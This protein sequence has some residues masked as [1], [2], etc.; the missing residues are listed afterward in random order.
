MRRSLGILLIFI[1]AAV[2]VLPSLIIEGVKFW[3][4]EARVVG[5]GPVVR[6]AVNQTGEIKLLPLEEY[7]VGVVAAEMPANFELEALKAQ[8][9]AAR[10]YTLKKINT[11]KSKPD[12]KH[13][14]A[15]VCTDAA[16][17]QA[18]VPESA[19]R[20]NWGLFNYLR[21]KGKIRQA[22]A[23]TGGLVLTYRGELIE[24]VYHS[25]SNG[26]TESA[27]AVWGYNIPYLQS[28]P[29]PWDRDSPRYRNTLTFT[30][31]QLEQKLG[32]ELKALPAAALI[33]PRGEAMKVLE[34]TPT[35]RVK[36]V[37]I[38]SKT[39]TG[40]DLRRLL[41]LSSTDFTWQVEGDKITFISVGNG[42]GVGLSQYGANG[43][44][45]EGKNFV[46]I[47]SHYYPG[48]RLEKR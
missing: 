45:K 35:G 2:I 37:K 5:K 27:E 38:G 15:D 41:G 43:M 30:L 7:L 39:F 14:Q 28:V 13:P 21:Y 23:A 31:G 40:P 6:L 26:R 20:R 25:T 36:A 4:P 29:S 17:C 42:H 8:A 34:Y 9:V 48:T 3:R 22:V 33:P 32:V 1:F 11:A 10:T 19:L 18:W 47:L 12:A 16:H 46:E 44:A 24:P